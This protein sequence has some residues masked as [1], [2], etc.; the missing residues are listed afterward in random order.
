MRPNPGLQ[1][2]SPLAH[3]SLCSL[4]TSLRFEPRCEKP[5]NKSGAAGVALLLRRGRAIVGHSGDCRAVLG[6]LDEE[7][8]CVTVNLTEDHKI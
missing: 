4:L 1:L 7:G 3:P 6:T 5:G 2:P 8:T